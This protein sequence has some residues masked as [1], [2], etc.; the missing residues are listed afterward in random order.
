MVARSGGSVSRLRRPLGCLA[1]V[2]LA[3]S[4]TATLPSVA[5]ADGPMT[6]TATDYLA[7]VT[8]APAGIDAK[9]V[10]GYLSLW[11]VQGPGR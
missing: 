10:D 9:V 2:L 8:H 4:A 7:R 5:S 3:V 11:A 6:P 1:A